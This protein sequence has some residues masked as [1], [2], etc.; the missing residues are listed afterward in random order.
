VNEFRINEPAAVAVA[1]SG[2]VDSSVAAALLVEEGHR[3]FGVTMRLWPYEEAPSAGRSCCSLA[4]VDAA[5]SVAARIGIPHYVVDLE[6]CFEQRVVRPF[7]LDYARGRTPNPCV[8]CNSKVKFEALMSKVSSMGADLLATGHYVLLT[9]EKDGTSNLKRAA[10]RDKDQSY[11]L[12]G[13]ER[14]L[15]PRLRF[16]IGSLD[17][18]TVRAAASQLGLAAVVREESQDVCFVGSDSCSE[19]VVRRLSEMGEQVSPGPVVDV[20]GAQLGTHRGLAHYTIGQRRGLGISSKGRMYVVDLRS[21]TNTVVLGEKSDLMAREFTCSN[22]NW[23]GDCRQEFPCE[24]LVQIRYTHTPAMARVEKAGENALRVRFHSEQ[25]SITP[26]QSAVFY[27]GDTLV[28]GGEI[29]VVRPGGF[30]PP[31][32]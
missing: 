22:V 11:V 20:R 30:E 27:D 10:D 18:E 12:W 21:G 17:K 28:G 26:G 29:E 31:A 13:I 2:G 8:V 9:Q 23:L 19:F 32:F 3:V 14:E 5:R 4:A 24:L 25:S 6:D 1:M 16:P 15:L 7:C